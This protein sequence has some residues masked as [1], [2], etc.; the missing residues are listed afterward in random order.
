MYR[1]E[2]RGV[3]PNEPLYFRQFPSRQGRVFPLLRFGEYHDMYAAVLSRIRDA[4]CL[5]YFGEAFQYHFLVVAAT[6]GAV[7]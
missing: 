3:F 2:R 5:F 6:Y 1:R 4:A 7:A